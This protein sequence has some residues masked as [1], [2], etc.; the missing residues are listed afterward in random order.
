M[1]FSAKRVIEAIHEL[2][3]RPFDEKQIQAHL[4]KKST[5][6]RKKKGTKTLSAKDVRTIQ[7]TCHLLSTIGYLEYAN[8]RYSL[9]PSFEG[10][11]PITIRAGGQ[12]EIHTDT[13][14]VIV[15][16]E[17]IADAHT[18]DVVTFDIT[19]FRGGLLYGRVTGIAKRKKE[20]YFART[21][22]KQGGFIHYRLI[23]LPGEW[24]A[25]S[26][27][28][29]NEP[30]EG[31]IVK[32]ELTGTMLAGQ[33]A[34]TVVS[35]PVT[36]SEAFDF[37]R[38][39]TKHDLPPLYSLSY[40][41][42]FTQELIETEKAGRTD[43]TGLFTITIDGKHAK[44]FDDAISLEIGPSAVT[45]YVH[46]ADVSAFVRPYDA[47]DK[48]ALSR[49]NSY[50]LGNRV[51][52]MLPEILSNNFC[53]LRHGEERLTMSAVMTFSH[54]MQLKK[55]SYR[56]SVINVNRRLT[57][58]QAD[59]LI[60]DS[61]DSTLSRLLSD[62]YRYTTALKKVRLAQGRLDLELTDF[63]LLYNQS[64][65]FSDIG[66][67]KRLRSH[68]IVEECMLAANECV[69]STIKKSGRP[70]IY[71]VHEQISKENWYKLKKLLSVFHVRLKGSKNPGVLLQSVIDE[72]RETE[73]S[74]VISLII[75]KSMMQA[76]YGT[77]PVGHFGLGFD[78]YTHFTSPIRRYS[79]LIVHRILKAIIEQ[80][81]SPYTVKELGPIAGKC[82]ERERIAQ[83]A[84][85]ELF[86]IKACRLMEKHIGE[87]YDA[88]ISGMNK[89]GI[90][91]AL[92][93][94]PIEGMVPFMRMGGDYYVLDEETL[95]ARGRRSG[96]AYTLGDR[97]S[98]RLVKSDH[99]L[100]Q[101]D[102]EFV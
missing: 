102:F 95:T 54:D 11:G 91:V 71:R 39:S 17:N 76:F 16:K 36:D 41:S 40:D 88:I 13:Y 92:T 64:G 100:A 87:T 48:E 6:T 94:R 57:Y 68:E 85:R 4:I 74:Y 59:A 63:E 25:A 83:K 46:I 28:F 10:K 27:R 1:P 26:K 69:A 70:G 38:V 14:D 50:Y 37:E 42:L 96:T 67:L 86:K 23:D 5:A 53:S 22:R 32:V 49:G 89:A 7:S 29:E 20:I 84:E 21:D 80:K 35:E 30:P 60:D 78:D 62:L 97:V 24:Y 12:G 56:K 55:V 79:D 90:F 34:C 98:V 99:L 51:I 44:D 93:D 19:D 82:S 73:S 3:N 75:L 65:K 18:D 72:Y 101:I 15:K 47:L 66:L 8:G 45:L 58:E 81:P 61:D 9:S 77:E 2:G 43:F 52:P 31:S 33:P